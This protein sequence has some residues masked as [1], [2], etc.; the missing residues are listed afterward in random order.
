MDAGCSAVW[1]DGS[2]GTQRYFNADPPN[3]TNIVLTIYGRI[4]PLQDVSAGAYSDTITATIN[5]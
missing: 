1:G 2:A 3:N 5:W 4:P